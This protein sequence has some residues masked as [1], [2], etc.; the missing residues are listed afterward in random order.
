M[1]VMKGEIAL[2]CGAKTNLPMAP[3][4]QAF[5]GLDE[6]LAYLEARG[7]RDFPF[8]KRLPDGTYRLITRVKNVRLIFTRDELMMRFGFSC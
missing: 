5:H 2:A 8:Y 7:P 3:A 6:Y 4:H 1:I